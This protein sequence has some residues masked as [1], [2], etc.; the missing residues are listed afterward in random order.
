LDTHA[1]LELAAPSA[2]DDF[3]L[4]IDG[5]LGAGADTLAMLK[6]V[7]AVVYDWDIATDA[8]SWSANV[9]ATLSGFEATALATGAGF[10]TCITPQSESSRFHAVHN[11]TTP[12]EGQGVAFR[13]NYRLL[14][15]EGLV[16][17]VEDF[18]R[19]FADGSGRPRRVH[20]VLRV[21]SR[22]PSAPRDLGASTAPPIED[23]FCSRR[24]FNEMVDEQCGAAASNG[25]QFAVL[26][27]G[28]DDLAA[29][30]RRDGFDAADELIAAAGLRLA[31]C[32][33]AG[34]RIARHAGGKFAILISL[35]SGD[36]LSTAV[37]RLA[38]AVNVEPLATSTRKVR[39]AARI[40]AV[41]APR[42]GRNA[43]LLL[44]R[45]DE[46]L[47]I[48]SEAQDRHAVYTPDVAA[49][50]SRRREMRVAEEIAA[51]LTE[52]RVVMAF[53]PVVPT[54][55]GRVGFREALL[56]VRQSD[57][58]L[59]GPMGL[60]P[61]AEKLGLIE[62]IDQRVLE[63]TLE[64]LTAAPDDRLS[65]NISAATLRSPYWLDRFKSGLRN[66]PGAAH[67]LIVEIVETQPVGDIKEAARLFCAMKALGARIAMDDFGAGHTSFRNLRDLGVDIVKI[68]GA[69][70]QNLARSPDDRFF[71]RTLVGLARHLEI[72]TVAEWVEDA[73]AAR[74]L[75]EWG[76]DYLQG[77]F[78]GRPEPAEVFGVTMTLSRR[79]A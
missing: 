25:R 78:L 75:T 70:V 51:A 8:V 38:R 21:L 36:H 72:E 57:G 33:R 67:R 34:D 64:R 63:L 37:R 16:H 9:D 43:H 74:I 47:E 19:W 44:Q 66:A 62:Q 68:D 18:G 71:V 29:I 35:A 60:L 15:T 12:D 48:A 32:L 56:R 76:V 27:V 4:A 24:A 61:V 45:A 59:A 52:R 31:N 53:Q 17:D 50:E 3:P 30:N 7:D 41:L 55:E 22:M 40:G 13:V 79:G 77:H 5:A 39:A 46:A 23:P 10:A 65:M 11:G 42:N 2:L 28:F 6:S 26:V 58:T 1:R 49:G 69:F 20:G 73:E 14:S 54:I